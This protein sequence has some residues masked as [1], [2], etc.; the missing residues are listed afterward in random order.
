MQ[1]KKGSAKHLLLRPQQLSKFYSG[2]RKS[3]KCNSG[4]LQLTSNLF[5]I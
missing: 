3:V 4:K 5:G 1:T 2:I